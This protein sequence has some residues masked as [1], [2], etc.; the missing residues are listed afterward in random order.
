MSEA[1]AVAVL[2]HDPGWARLFEAERERLAAVLGERAVAIEHIGSTS[3]A[4]LA[5]KPIVDIMVGFEDPSDL[6][7]AVGR[8]KALG[9][10]RQPLGDF[11]GRLFLTL[12]RDGVPVVHLSLT[13]IAAPYWAPH[14]LFRDRLRADPALS[15]RYAALKLRL[16]AE[17]ADDPLA[18]GKGKSDFV[19]AVCGAGWVD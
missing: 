17:H 16:V 14:L 4:G 18:Y 11:S 13:P 12:L 15:L 6:P 9:Y 1:R 3:V 7:E 2:E 10:E 8:V 5:A 19:E